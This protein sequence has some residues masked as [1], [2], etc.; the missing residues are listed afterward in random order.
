MLLNDFGYYNFEYTIDCIKDAW[1]DFHKNPNKYKGKEI[2][3]ALEQTERIMHIQSAVSVSILLKSEF[4]RN[5][6]FKE[7]FLYNHIKNTEIE[8]LKEPILF[9][10]EIEAEASGIPMDK[11]IKLEIL[12]ENDSKYAK[13][14]NMSTEDIFREELNAWGIKKESFAYKCVMSLSKVGFSG[15][16]YKNAIKAVAEDI[17][18]NSGIV[19][20]AFNNIA[21]KAN[22]SRS[23]YNPVLPKLQHVIKETLVR[24]LLDFCE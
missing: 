12:G 8:Q 6:Q 21:N 4:E 7:A 2:D 22:F 23:I 9:T 15:M 3:W 14:D 24:E 16:T 19:S 1:E 17:G 18:T 10:T 13:L 20:A 11:E 5:A